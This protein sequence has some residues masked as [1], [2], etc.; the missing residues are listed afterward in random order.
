[1]FY[2]RKHKDSKHSQKRL[3]QML[4]LFISIIYTLTNET[5]SKLICIKN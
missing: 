3:E 2:R 1:M 4:S 5:Y